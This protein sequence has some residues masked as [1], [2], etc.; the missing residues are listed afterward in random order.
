[1]NRS[2]RPSPPPVGMYCQPRSALVKT[3]ATLLREFPATER[4][5]M[6]C[7]G[8][9]SP[10]RPRSQATCVCRDRVVGV[11]SR[12][13]TVEFESLETRWRRASVLGFPTL[14]RRRSLADAAALRGVSPG[15]PCTAT[16]YGSC[17]ANPGCVPAKSRGLVVSHPAPPGFSS[18]RY[19]PRR[20]RIVTVTKRP[21]AASPTGLGG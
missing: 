13:A 21:G 20:V 8:A 14:S 12:S 17:N 7:V 3:T 16:V 11:A 4:G 15:R 6:S 10:T 1:V 18:R 9:K 5:F 2:S 19:G